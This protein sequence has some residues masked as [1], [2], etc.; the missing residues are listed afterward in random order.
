MEEYKRC[1]YCDEQIRYN[2]VKCKHCGS[3][4]TNSHQ[5]PSGI[6]TPETQIKLALSFKY[7][8][9]EEIGR[10]GMASV[11][12]ANQKNLNRLVA[13]KVI[14]QNLIYDNEFLQR[15]HQEAKLCASVNHPNIV[16]I[17]DEGALNNIHYMAMEYLSGNDLQRIIR[18]SKKVV[19][20]DAIKIVVSIANALDHAHNKGLI[21]RD[22]KSSN[23]IIT[24]EGRAVLTDFGI[25]YAANSAKL[26][27]TGSVIGTPEYMSPEQAK[28]IK[29]DHRSDIYSLGVVLFECITGKLPFAG[30][31]PLTTIFKIINDPPPL[32]REL[33]K[34]VPQW[35][36]TVINKALEKKPEKRF[37]TGKQF[38]LALINKKPVG[39]ELIS[40]KK[41]SRTDIKR[42]RNEK[43]NKPDKEKNRFNKK[44]IY[45]FTILCLVVFFIG[46]KLIPSLNN[47][48]EMPK[49]YE[50]KI[51]KQN[52][53]RM[54][55]N[56]AEGLVRN[57]D[58]LSPQGNNA[59]IVYSEVLDMEPENDLAK[60]GLENIRK[61]YLERSKSE[62]TNS[63]FK[64]SLATSDSALEY[65]QDNTE[66]L[67]INKLAK[68]KIESQ[69]IEAERISE[70]TKQTKV[71]NL[72]GLQITAA[73]DILKVNRLRV[74][75]ISRV[76]SPG[77]VGTVINQFP[78]GGELTNQESYVNLVV[79]E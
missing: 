63:E 38:A 66:L 36:S 7:E 65:F 6:I 55:L 43:I 8:I 47:N 20:E 40:K 58:L 22:I 13:L 33:N 25:A 4:I 79:G 75:T 53:I 76:I 34:E 1:P 16:T 45:S 27:Q 77:R 72:I 18:Y 67:N 26:T 56:E 41:I 28:G 10:G 57:G 24:N 52:N 54:L 3:I 61:S 23:I 42:K 29:T 73:G 19:Y 68:Q 12:K 60:M 50:P 48:K 35:L 2:A 70:E 69:K 15:F 30:D 21:H 32:A 11:Y 59:Y 14:H 64:Q 44:I 9:I 62:L 37:Q 71:P 74:G 51:N 5:V 78:R 49:N 46:Y 39:L 31:N 17:Y